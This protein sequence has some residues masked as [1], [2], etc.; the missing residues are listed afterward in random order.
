[1]GVSLWAFCCAHAHKVGV[2]RANGAAPHPP[3]PWVRVWARGFAP[4]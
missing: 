1:M 4:C 3:T 2:L